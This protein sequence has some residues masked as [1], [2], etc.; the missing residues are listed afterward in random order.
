M[1]DAGLREFFIDGKL[2]R[3]NCI[4]GRC[5][6]RI[7]AFRDQRIC[8]GGYFILRRPCFFNG[9]NP[10]LF[11]DL[12]RVGNR[13]RGRILAL[14]IQQADLLCI[15]IL[16]KNQIHNGFCIQGVRSPGNIG[17][18]CIQA[19]HQFRSDRIRNGR[20]YN[21]NVLS[22][23]CRLHDLG[24]RRRHRHDQIHIVTD[25]LG[26][27]LVQGS[28]VSLSVKL[29]IPVVE[30]NSQLL[31]LCVQLLLQVFHNLI[32]GSMIHI[33]NDANLKL[34]ACRRFAP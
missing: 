9:L 26:G 13:L 31:S 25:Q 3:H 24:G 32:Q 30:S 18:R 21:R 15:R 2:R 17:A 34:R 27:D 16:S 1:G 7:H 19:V 23:C 22:L 20:K 12:F 33:L 28:P 6:Y 29:I 14:G 11:Q 8:R 10:L 5:E 4:I